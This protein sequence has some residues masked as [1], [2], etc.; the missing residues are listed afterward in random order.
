MAEYYC[1]YCDMYT[2]CESN[3]TGEVLRCLEC[4]KPLVRVLEV[5]ERDA[6]EIADET[7]LEPKLS[8]SEMMRLIRG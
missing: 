1:D 5:A 8:L 7:D 4:E 2:T 6:L 3:T